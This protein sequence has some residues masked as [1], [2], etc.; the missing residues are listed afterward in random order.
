MFPL[1]VKVVCCFL[2]VALIAVL[3]NANSGCGKPS[4]LSSASNQNQAAGPAAYETPADTDPVDPSVVEKI[5]KEKWAGDLGGMV[6]RRYIRVLVSYN[7]TY[8]FYDGPE[9]RGI[10]YEGMKEFERFVNQKLNTGRQPVGMIF[11][12]VQRSDLIKGLI[13]GRGD[14]AA[15]NIGITP[16]GR[17]VID[18]SDPVGDPQPSVVATGPN[19]PA[20]TTI[21]DLSGKE[22]YVRKFSRYWPALER[23][24]EQFKQSGKPAMTLKPADEALEDEDIL[25]MVQAG[26]VGITVVDKVVGALWAQVFTS[27]T[28]H[29]DVAVGDSISAGWAFRKGSPE[30][31]SLVNEFVKDHRSGTAFG[32]T[33]IRRYFQNTKWIDNATAEEERQK[34]RETVAFF[35]KYSGQY[36]FDWLLVAA[37]GY[38]ESRLDQTVQSSAGAVGVMQIKPTTAAGEPIN[39]NDVSKAEANIHAGVKYMRF[40]MDQ[41]FKDAPMDKT[42][43]GLF[44]FASYNAGP[45]RVAKL[46]K[47][48]QDEGLDPNKW[49]N[50]VEL[51]AGREIG[52]ETVTYVSNIYKYYV[53]FKLVEEAER[54]K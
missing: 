22:I 25:E 50:N 36:G 7:R 17:A 3:L 37:Q 24:N 5:K 23:L 38:Q 10:V 34:Y 46:R 54:K 21:D 49:F 47:M 27:L 11:I 32:N 6:A 51:I 44:A 43:K 41:Y 16:E 4:D 45:A 28:L 31:A 18:Y 40:M 33:L 26:V 9:A 2:F 48:A 39:I 15:S 35:K 13:D 20:I 8:Y 19:S 30:L 29:P 53:A 12:P 42:N 14:I 1:M 52:P